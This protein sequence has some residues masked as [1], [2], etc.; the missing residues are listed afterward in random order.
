MGGE[1]IDGGDVCDVRDVCDVCDGCDV[2]DGDGLTFAFGSGQPIARGRTPWGGVCKRF[3]PARIS[4]S[5]AEG[6]REV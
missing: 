5:S 1:G 6:I 4:N 2:R 3:I